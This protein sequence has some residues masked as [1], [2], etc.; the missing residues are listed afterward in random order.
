MLEYFLDDPRWQIGQGSSWHLGMY[1]F[2]L[3]NQMNIGLMMGV[4]ERDTQSS[5]DDG[6]DMYSSQNKWFSGAFTS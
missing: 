6:H 5:A 4:V 2:C 1:V 3:R